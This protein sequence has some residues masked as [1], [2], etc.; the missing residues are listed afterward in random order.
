MSDLSKENNP[1]ILFEKAAKVFSRG[2]VKAI[3]SRGHDFIE[4]NSEGSFVYDTDGTRYIDCFSGASTYNLGRKN[5]VL[6][7][8]LKLVSHEVDQGVF[9]MISE[10][11]ARLAAK[12]A[13][14]VP[15]NLDCSLMQVVRGEAFDAACK[16]A[17]GYTG[18]ANLVSVDG[19]WYGE[20]GF[21]VNLSQRSDHEQ[22]GNPMPETHTI[23]YGDLAALKTVI[24]RK[25]A[26]VI[27]ETIQAENHCRS[28]DG[29][30]LKEIRAQCDRKGALLIIDETQTGFGRTG[31]R[32]SFEHFDVQP[33]ILIL[34]E[35]MAGGIFPMSGIVFTAEVKNLFED[36]PMIHLNTFGGH[37]VG[38][39]V[40]IKALEMYEQPKPWENAVEKGLRLQKGLKMIMEKFPDFIKSVEG[41]GLLLSIGL[42][43]REI[44]LE[45]CRTAKEQGIVVVPGNVNNKS[46]ILRPSLLISDGEIDFI[47]DAVSKTV[48][49]IQTGKVR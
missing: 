1:E 4:T 7:E 40:A 12:L 30:Y 38:C 34:G 27:L 3:K 49:F 37:D 41:I 17:R 47:I 5:P 42:P 6:M 43:N 22:F 2:L 8:T 39:L 44:A 21:A 31:C 35:A 20:T 16:V 15:G 19:G 24:N 18:R 48:S 28:I 29:K 9:L 26:A 32:F 14:F 25:T 10:Q 23:P 36:H 46:V 33:D 13:D 45:F 11:K